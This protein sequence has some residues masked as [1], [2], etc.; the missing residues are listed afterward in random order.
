MKVSSSVKLGPWL[1]LAS[2][3]QLRQFVAK[4]AGVVYFS[5]SFR[6][7]SISP[8]ISPS[9]RPSSIDACHQIQA[10]TSISDLQS[11]HSTM[12]P[13]IS[14]NAAAALAFCQQ[15]VKLVLKHSRTASRGDK[16]ALEDLCIHSAQSWLGSVSGSRAPPSAADVNQA[17]LC[18]H[19]LARIQMAVR[20]GLSA[21]EKPSPLSTGLVELL[22][23][24]SDSLD[25]NSAAA[26]L[27]HA[28]Q[29]NVDDLDLLRPILTILESSRS[30]LDPRTLSQCVWALGKVRSR[31]TTS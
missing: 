22:A 18:L 8:S 3:V 21:S 25:P 6:N 13:S 31:G 27:H 12:R 26:T 28:A 10:C 24:G 30:D 16:Q 19:S 29:L 4:P 17:S 2:I 9:P 5:R 23:R 20:G 15:A 11:L 1:P 14:A 7:F